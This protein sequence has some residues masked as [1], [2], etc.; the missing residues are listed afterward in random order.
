MNQPIGTATTKVSEIELK[1]RERDR[2]TDRQTDT[3]TDRQIHSQ[4]Q[5]DKDRQRQSQ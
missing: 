2:R 4:R 3:E 1:D 5:I